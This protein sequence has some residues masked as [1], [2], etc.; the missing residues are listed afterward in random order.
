MLQNNE[1]K[2]KRI[3]SVFLGI[4]SVARTCATQPSKIK[5]EFGTQLHPFGMKHCQINTLP[6]LTK[7]KCNILEQNLQNKKET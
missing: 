3:T 5:T 7:K 1:S 4:G 6:F 2:Q